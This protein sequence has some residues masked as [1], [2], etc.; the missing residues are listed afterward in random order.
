MGVEK[1]ILFSNP[2]TVDY[3]KIHP[4]TQMV[5]NPSPRTT[6][7]SK[8]VLS[9]GQRIPPNNTH[10]DLVKEIPC[11]FDLFWRFFNFPAFCSRQIVSNVLKNIRII[12]GD[13]NLP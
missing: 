13:L 4:I 7:F 9:G 8:I 3:C 12:I 11:F 5:P 1:E 2:Y 10:P 6:I